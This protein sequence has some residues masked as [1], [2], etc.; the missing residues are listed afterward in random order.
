MRK[1]DHTMMVVTGLVLAVGLGVFAERMSNGFGGPDV[2]NGRPVDDRFILR[3]GVSAELDVLSNDGQISGPIQIVSAPDCGQVHVDAGK[4]ILSGTETCRRSIEFAYCV[5]QTSGC[6][7]ARVSVALQGQPVRTAASPRKAEPENIPATDDSDLVAKLDLSPL[8]EQPVVKPGPEFALIPT[9]RIE[10]ASLRAFAAT[11]EDPAPLRSLAELATFLADAGSRNQ[12]TQW[13]ED[14]G[15][16]RLQLSPHAPDPLRAAGFLRSYAKAPGDEPVVLAS[17]DVPSW[18]VNA[19]DDRLDVTLPAQRQFPQPDAAP[20]NNTSDIEQVAARFD[21]DLAA[22]DDCPIEG[23]L[24]TA[25]GAHLTLTLS[26]PCLAGQL[27]VARSFGLDFLL[28]VSEEGGLVVDLPALE[29]NA[30]VVVDPGMGRAPL[31]L[32][33]DGSDVLRVER[34]VFRMVRSTGLALAAVEMSPGADPVTLHHANAR[35]HRDAFLAGHGYVRR[36]PSTDG[37]QIEV[38]T[39]PL[40][41]QVLANVVDMR[42]IKDGAGQ[43]S[44]PIRLDYLHLGSGDEV[45]QT[46]TLPITACASR[47]G[48]ALRN[49][50]GP[51][52]VASQ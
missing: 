11:L 19:G 23:N 13:G 37:R 15:A 10:D 7:Q 29:I 52:K 42:L 48:Y 6:E 4:L 22:R 26:A 45:L 51:I 36:Y 21:D 14:R 8:P 32:T 5:G 25:P 44:G 18:T 41:R 1:D 3:A 46:T 31:T 43:C 9:N 39:L 49:V 47:A 12:L 30:E 2:Q 35:S 33:A 28:R 40:S 50:V 38:Y 27:V 20:E 34:S 16:I 17:L 24:A